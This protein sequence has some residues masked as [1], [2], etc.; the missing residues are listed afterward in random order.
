MMTAEEFKELQPGDRIRYNKAVA[1]VDGW[2]NNGLIV[3]F[4]DR[5]SSTTIFAD[6]RE[7]LDHLCAC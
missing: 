4:E 7:W 5:A 2:F 3:W 1:V 6:Q